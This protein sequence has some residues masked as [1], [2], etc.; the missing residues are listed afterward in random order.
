M[1]D[2]MFRTVKNA[3]ASV[4]LMGLV[5][6]QPAMAVRSSD[7]LPSTHVTHV[8]SRVGTPVGNVDSVRGHPVYGW[9]IGGVIFAAVL[10]IVISDHN[11]NKSPG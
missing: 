1:G 2:S 10:A 7:S 3:A 11:E 6:S 5:I 9:L 4:A 8:E